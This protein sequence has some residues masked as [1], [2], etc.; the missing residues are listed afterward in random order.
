MHIFLQGPLGIGKSTVIEKTIGLLSGVRRIILGGFNTYKARDGSPYIYI[1]APK[2]NKPAEAY[3]IAQLTKDGLRV[4]PEVFDSEGVLL[5]SNIDNADLI[6]MDEL[7]FLERQSYMFQ[8]RV[9]EC[10]DGSVPILGVLRDKVIPWHLPIKSHPSVSILRVNEDN[11][12]SLP[13]YLY[14]TLIK[15]VR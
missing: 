4:H 5:L 12:G 15:M 3:C 11:R 1:S 13:E 10:L 9:L 6:C 8:R 14:N 2:Q 7:G